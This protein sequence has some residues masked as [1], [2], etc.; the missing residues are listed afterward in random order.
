VRDSD[1][2]R[3][4]PRGAAYGIAHSSNHGASWTGN[5]IENDGDTS[6]RDWIIAHLAP[7]PMFVFGTW[8]VAKP[9][10][11][12]QTLVWDKGPASGM[13]DLSF[14]WKNSFEE[15]YVLGDGFS[16]RR[17]EAVLRGHN[18]IT[19]ESKGRRHQ[20][21][22]PVTLMCALINKHPSPLILDPTCGVGPA[23]EAAKLCG[24]RAIGIEINE[25]YCQIAA[26]RLRQGVLFA[27]GA[28]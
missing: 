9:I 26:D 24:R 25:D 11:V 17:D 14:P 27:G 6:L 1:L 5:E 4:L 10:G 15:I 28:A 16:G 18:I 21:E 12:R 3:G 19:W 13:G 8:K 7:R 2:P 23:L 22:K 20:H